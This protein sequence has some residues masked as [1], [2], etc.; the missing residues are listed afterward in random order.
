MN[1]FR[2]R[3]VVKKEKKKNK[4]K[5]KQK[6]KKKKKKKKNHSKQNTCVS[7]FYS[8]GSVNRQTSY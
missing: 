2:F 6:T 3:E 1:E 8:H 7:K 4:Q 5:A